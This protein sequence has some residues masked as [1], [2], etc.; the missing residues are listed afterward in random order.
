MANSKRLYEDGYIFTLILTITL[1]YVQS[2]CY[3]NVFAMHNICV[4]MCAC[5][6]T[7]FCI[8]SIHSIDVLAY[9]TVKYRKEWL[10]GWLVGLFSF[11]IDGNPSGKMFDAYGIQLH[12]RFHMQIAHTEL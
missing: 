1:T 7:L 5:F 3:G 12:G 6:S 9:Y 10:A 8:S 4:C 2:G 11:D